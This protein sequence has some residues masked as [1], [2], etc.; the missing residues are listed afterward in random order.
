MRC[1]SYDFAVIGGD[2]RQ[3]YLAKKLEKMGYRVCTYALCEEIKGEEDTIKMV[4][5]MESAV[6][7]SKVIL[8]PIPLC[9]QKDGEVKF[10]QR[11]GEPIFIEKLLQ[12]IQ[13]GQMLFAGCIP[14]EMKE[15][16]LE[17]G[18]IIFDYMKRKEIAIYNSIATTE[19]VLAEAIAKSPRNIHGSR[20][21]VLGYG[22]CGK[23]LVQYLKSMGARVTVCVRREEVMAEASIIAERAVLMGE[24]SHVLKGSHFVFNT[25]PD[26][27]LKKEILE[28]MDRQT[29]IYDIASGSGGVDFE[30]AKELGIKAYSCPGLPGR[31]APESSAEILANVIKKE[32]ENQ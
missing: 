17:R 16:L 32:I 3:V 24:M 4:D 13:E 21:V 11:G 30:S 7:S 6:K 23:T 29:E 20:S 31:Y 27:V 25:I 14:E 15:D 10:H 28:Q 1:Y 22:V 8:A 19:G 26:K 2:R 9:L 18:V 5:S 12:E